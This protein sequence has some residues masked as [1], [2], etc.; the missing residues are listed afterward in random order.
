MIARFPE[1][2]IQAVCSFVLRNTRAAQDVQ[3]MLR[4]LE[5]NGTCGPLSQE[6]LTL[7]DKSILDD[8]RKTFGHDMIA[9]VEPEHDR[10]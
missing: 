6:L 1:C 3:E 9:P 4:S 5:R 8:F 10:P 7:L 2:R